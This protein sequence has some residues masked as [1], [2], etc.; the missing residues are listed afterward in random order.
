MTLP[1]TRRGILR[2][3][4][5]LLLAGGVAASTAP[6]PPPND[7]ELLAACALFAAAAQEVARLEA[8]RETPDEVF[9]PAN[10]ALHDALIRVSR[11]PARTTAGVRAKAAVCGAVLRIDEPSAMAGRFDL[12]ARRHDVLAWSTLIDLV[13]LPG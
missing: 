5:A 9:E 7:A 10:D 13:D 8:I 11:L 6:E 12:E 2:S 1:Q 3:S 4:A